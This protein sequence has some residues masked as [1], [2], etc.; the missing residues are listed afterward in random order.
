M[1]ADVLVVGTGLIG[2]SLGLA[3][4]GRAD[5]LLDDRDPAALATAAGRGAGRRWDGREPARLAV[6]CT[7]PSA[8]AATVLRLQRAEVAASYTHVS[9]VQAPVQAALDAAGCALES[10]CGSHPM[11]GR[12]RGGPD[13]ALAGLF[14]GR[15]W[16]LCPGPQTRET[17]LA[18]VRDVVLLAGGAPVQL[19]PD[20]HDAAVALISHLPQV[21]ASALAAQLPSGPPEAVA[22]AGPGLQDS[23]RIAASDPALWR[24]V[25][26]LNAAVVAPLVRGL[27]ADLSAVAEALEAGQE[28][29]VVGLLT[30]GVA[31][32]ALVPVKRGERDAA[33]DVVAVSVSDTPGQL[34]GLLV[35]ARDSGV[36]VEDVRVDHVPGTP[37]G[38][39]ALSVRAGVRGDLERAL[40]AAGWDVLA[41]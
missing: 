6:V 2:T 35:A 33:F 25:L 31:G 26:G 8:V 24:E 22:L 32:R 20:S 5:V 1:T 17:V 9:S 12:E 18:D 11:A 7:P 14:A 15:A 4:Q 30:R 27:A 34:A 21:A 37:R 29:P 10:V 38:T 40:R 36:N 23:T 28:G 19:A 16:A 41:R 3:L 39:I 13:A